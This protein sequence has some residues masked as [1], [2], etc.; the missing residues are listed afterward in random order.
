MR[1]SL[2]SQLKLDI[3]HIKVETGRY[4][5][6]SL[7]QSVWPE[8]LIRWSALHYNDV[9]MSTMAYQITGLTIVYSVVYLSADQRKHLSSAS[10]AF[11]RGIHRRPVNS[12][13][14]GQLR[15][16]CFHLLTPSCPVLFPKTNS[17]SGSGLDLS[18]LRGFNLNFECGKS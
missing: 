2:L 8:N 14:K 15:G 7:F 12:H 5:G 4:R 16:I 9:I 6:I 10:L 18:L 11:V 3:L 13:T 1:S 17:G